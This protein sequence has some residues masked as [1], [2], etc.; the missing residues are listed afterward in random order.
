M[1]S[2]A[3]RSYRA[4]IRAQGGRN[5]LRKPRQAQA[6]VD[7]VRA[8]PEVAQPPR[9]ILRSVRL[10][11][12]TLEFD[13]GANWP[14]YDLTPSGLATDAPGLLYLHGGAYV[15]Q[16][17]QEAW[18]F[19]A[20]VAAQ[21]KIRLTVAIYPL[22][23][24]ITADKLVPQAAHALQ[25]EQQRAPGVILMGDSAGGGLA[26]AAT[27]A[28]RAAGAKLPEALVLISPWTD[29]T[30]SHPDVTA[31]ERRDI[32][33]APAGLRHFGSLY[34]GELAADDWRVSPLG[35]ELSGL[36]PMQVFAAE[37]DVLYSDAIRLDERVRAAG[38]SSEL[39]IGQ[40]MLHDW[41]LANIPEGHEAVERIVSFVA[42]AAGRNV[43][44]VPPQN[45]RPI[46]SR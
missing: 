10:E 46:E 44:P 13:G 3:S 6:Y 45:W 9:G 4:A 29:I 8:T 15:S 35:A 42:R 5:S 25:H 17:N 7:A 37:D 38:G 23:P 41:P 34:R 21:S 19:A 12:R 36:P 14:M 24:F 26:L 30:L 31:R 39:H 33:L 2:A 16:I 40:R 22:V 1:P 11:H 43:S 27:I 18:Y 32:M 20:R 28:A